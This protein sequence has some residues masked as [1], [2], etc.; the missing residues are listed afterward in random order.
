MRFE[1]GWR[2]AKACAFPRTSRSSSSSLAEASHAAQ[3]RQGRHSLDFYEPI[4]V[5]KPVASIWIVDGPEIRFGVGWLKFPFTH[6]D[7][8]AALWRAGP[9]FVCEILRL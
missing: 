9:A 1:N 8:S 4:N 3:A 5:L 6:N 7:P 2:C